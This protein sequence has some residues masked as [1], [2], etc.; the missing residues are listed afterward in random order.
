MNQ[1][2]VSLWSHVS[3]HC[4]HEKKKPFWK[5]WLLR[6]CNWLLFEDLK[7][8]LKPSLALCWWSLSN[9]G[10]LHDCRDSASCSLAR[11]SNNHTEYII[12]T[13]CQAY[14]SSV[15]LA[16][17]YI[18]KWLIS[19]IATYCGLLPFFCFSSYMVSPWSCLFF[20][21][22]SVQIFCLVIFISA[23]ANTGSLLTKWK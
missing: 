3:T 7:Y 5:L 23:K 20:Y 16:S 17:S 12:I 4:Q 8:F 15:Y 6:R 21:H 18:I 10:H 14:G 11:S 19:I 1:K 2:A 13:A 9:I 22:I